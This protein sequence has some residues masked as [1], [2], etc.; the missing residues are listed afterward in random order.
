MSILLTTL[1]F[2][3]HKDG[4]KKVMSE[5]LNGVNHHGM[6]CMAM[7]LIRVTL[8]CP[9]A[10]LHLSA[11][12]NVSRTPGLFAFHTRTFLTHQCPLEYYGSSALKS[13]RQDEPS[14][15]D[16]LHMGPWLQHRLTQ[17]RLL[18]TPL[19]AVN[20]SA[21]MVAVH[22]SQMA[23]ISGYQRSATGKKNAVMV[24]TLWRLYL[25]LVLVV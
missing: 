7:W 15:E 20:S 12:W 5:T 25:S 2:L 24:H 1:V 9:K 17:G 8:T 10:R 3:S 19:T 21:Q 14:L 11:T 13:A 18:G 16:A 4:S 6:P 23:A 22:P